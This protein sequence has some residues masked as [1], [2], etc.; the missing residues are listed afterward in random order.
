MHDDRDAL[1]ELVE[2]LEGASLR[3]HV[4]VGNYFQEIHGWSV[5]E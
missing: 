5:I 1:C 3:L 4:I 2:H